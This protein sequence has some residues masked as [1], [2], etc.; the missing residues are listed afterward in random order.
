MSKKLIE[1]I[2]LATEL[3]EEGVRTEMEKLFSSSGADFNT[4]DIEE[5]RKVLARYLQD[6]FVDIKSSL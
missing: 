2:I 6:I 1:E 3:P 5:I 4:D